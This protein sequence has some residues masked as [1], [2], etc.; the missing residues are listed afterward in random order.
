MR[1]RDY[2]RILQLRIFW[3]VL[4]GNDIFPVRRSIFLWGI[5]IVYLLLV[6]EIHGLTIVFYW[7]NKIS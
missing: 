7:G 4:W 1:G 5:V 3:G 6:K 2:R